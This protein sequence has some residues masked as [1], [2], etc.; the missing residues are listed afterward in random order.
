[1]ACQK[2][3]GTLEAARD[4]G[5]S[6]DRVGVMARPCSGAR[7]V[8]MAGFGMGEDVGPLMGLGWPLAGVGGRRVGILLRRGE[9]PSWDFLLTH[10]SSCIVTV[11][12]GPLA[13]HSGVTNTPL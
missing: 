8:L 6:A 9:R 11:S 4:R 2:L 12:G 1:M 5:A 10:R 13:E 7:I 3:D